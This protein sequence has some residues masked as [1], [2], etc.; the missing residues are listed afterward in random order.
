MSLM[1]LPPERSPE[2]FADVQLPGGMPPLENPDNDTLYYPEGDGDRSAITDVTADIDSALVGAPATAPGSMHNREQATSEDQETQRANAPTEMSVPSPP[3]HGNAENTTPAESDPTLSTDN[4]AGGAK[5]KAVPA[6]HTGDM[7]PINHDRKPGEETEQSTEK[8]PDRPGIVYGYLSPEGA[9]GPKAAEEL[10]ERNVT[11]VAIDMLCATE[12]E[13][14]E[15]N[16]RFTHLLSA[17]ALTQA[18][19]DPESE[20]AKEIAKIQEGAEQGHVFPGI[21]SKLLGSDVEI[22]L[23]GPTRD[24][25]NVARNKELFEKTAALTD[26][27]KALAPNNELAELA[28]QATDMAAACLDANEK[29]LAEWAERLVREHPNAKVGIMTS[30]QHQP[31][32]ARVS[33]DIPAERFALNKAGQQ[34]PATL[35]NMLRLAHEMRFGD[36]ATAETLNRTVLEETFAATH[37]AIETVHTAEDLRSAIARRTDEE[38]AQLLN[39]LDE[40]KQQASSYWDLRRRSNHLIRAL[41]ADGPLDTTPPL[42]YRELPPGTERLYVFNTHSW[43]SGL[44]IAQEINARGIKRIALEAATSSEKGRRKRAENYTFLS[45]RQGQEHIANKPDGHF[46]RMAANLYTQERGQ[47]GGTLEGLRGSDAAIHIMD[48]PYNHPDLDYLRQFITK[49]KGLMEMASSR[50]V[51]TATLTE[52]ILDAAETKLYTGET[53]E[54]YM[55]ERLDELSHEY[56]G[57]PVA[58]VV[59]ANHDP[60]LGMVDPRATVD[61]ITIDGAGQL[62]SGYRG[63]LVRIAEEM[64]FG[65]GPT[66]ATLAKAALEI[67]LHA[68]STSSSLPALVRYLDGKSPDELQALLDRVD[69]IKIHSIN[70]AGYR[71]QVRLLIQDLRFGWPSF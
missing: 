42:P 65:D 40:A 12:Q 28:L 11:V 19:Q 27:V 33:S 57:E 55:A 36:G 31:M 71:T 48:M 1:R 59:G 54:R 62:R 46:G 14:T 68:S 18:E 64:R 6:D 41:E 38:V 49:A 2:G 10:L 60:L 17:A 53:R 35:S 16:A 15:E 67:S 21:L 30:G 37:G 66:E 56:P 39:E 47:I 52:K 34:S 22:A 13:R 24:H 70:D 43:A 5:D 50:Q 26:A 29:Y 32:E 8:S 3:A 44:R 9:A 51:S 45:S 63:V 61:Q 23:V 20:I 7:S 69:R 4:A 25:P 58:V